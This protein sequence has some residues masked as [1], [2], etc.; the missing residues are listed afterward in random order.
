MLGLIRSW[1]PRAYRSNQASIH[2]GF[3]RIERLPPMRAWCNSRRS[4]AV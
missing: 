1:A 4:H 3:S 2:S